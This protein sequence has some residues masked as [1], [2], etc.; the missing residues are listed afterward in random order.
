MIVK[1]V[2]L[3]AGYAT[4]LFPLTENKP[5]A[6]LEFWGKPILNYIFDNMDKIDEIDEVY[7]VSNS[8]FYNNFSEWAKTLSTS[9]VIHVVDDGTDSDSNKLGAIGDLNMLLNSHKIDDDM[10]VLLGDNLFTYSLLEF[11]KYFKKVNADCVCVKHV[12]ELEELQRIGVV[13]LA[14]D[15]KVISFEEKPKVPKSDLGAFGAYIYKK[16]TIPLVKRYVDEGNNVD[17]PGNLPA[18]LC[19]RQDVYAY[20]FE[21]ECFDI[22]TV[23]SYKEVQENYKYLFVK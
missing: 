18:W 12:K 10:M 2:I 20:V 22:G 14:D 19:K 8:R 6:L 9:K 17:A 7:I 3:V 16:E 4:R 1:A 23:A 15:Q 21:G 13:E 5:K 11:Y